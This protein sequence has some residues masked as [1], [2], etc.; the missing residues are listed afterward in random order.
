MKCNCK[1]QLSYFLMQHVHLW[2]DNGKR[3]VA[4]GWLGLVIECFAGMVKNLNHSNYQAEFAV[5]QNKIFIGHSGGYLSSILQTG[6]WFGMGTLACYSSLIHQKIAI[7]SWMTR[8]ISQFSH[9]HTEACL[10]GE[11]FWYFQNLGIAYHNFFFIKK[12]GGDFSLFF[13]ISTEFRTLF[14]GKAKLKDLKEG[15]LIFFLAGNLW[16]RK[17]CF[18]NLY[19][20]I[21]KDYCL[22][23]AIF[24]LSHANV[25]FIT[26]TFTAYHYINFTSP[27]KEK[28]DPVTSVLDW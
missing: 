25:L 15:I 7:W 6:Q 16:G 8:K 11:N 26:D 24:L 18:S 13:R 2:V 17:P 5:P 14:V 10:T 23:V 27:E 28:P 20:N 21:K 4:M 22:K 19:L 12:V 1:E 3:N 9:C